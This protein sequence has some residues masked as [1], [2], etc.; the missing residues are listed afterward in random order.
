MLFDIEPEISLNPILLVQIKFCKMNG[1]LL[2]TGFSPTFFL[3]SFEYTRKRLN[4]C[5]MIA[6]KCWLK[7]TNLCLVQKRM[8]MQT[9]CGCL[10]TLLLYR[11]DLNLMLLIWGSLKLKM[12]VGKLCSLKNLM[13]ILPFV[14]LIFNMFASLTSQMQCGLPWRYHT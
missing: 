12:S 9:S 6:M 5:S 14:V 2:H 4:I 3:V 10:I 1:M 8:Q 11:I 7:S 13:R